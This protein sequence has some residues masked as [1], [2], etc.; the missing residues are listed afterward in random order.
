VKGQQ[1]KYSEDELE[2]VKK[3]CKLPTR[4]QYQLFQGKFNRPD[5]SYMNHNALR[6]RNGWLTG[7]TGRFEKGNIPHPDARP[8][9]PNKTSFKKGAKPHNWKPV[10]SRRISR[11]GYVEVKTQEPKKWEQLHVLVWSEENGDVP[12]GYCIVFKDGDKLNVGL[13]NL[14]LISR[15]ELLQINRLRCSSQP[16]EVQPVIR[17]MGKVIAKT[18]EMAT[19]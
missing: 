13:D 9:G 14:D 2:F 10:G 4:E 15:N 17:V 19:A 5:V 3:H 7:R 18:N 1:I 8:K 11:D 6:K 12:E 16:P